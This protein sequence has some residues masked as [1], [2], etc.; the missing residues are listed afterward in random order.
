MSAI[1]PTSTCLHDEALI[2]ASPIVINSE[3]KPLA[4]TLDVC[5][6]LENTYWASCRGFVVVMKLRWFFDLDSWAGKILGFAKKSLLP[7]AFIH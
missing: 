6:R 5:G 2:S 1:R 4:K 3:V 7:Q